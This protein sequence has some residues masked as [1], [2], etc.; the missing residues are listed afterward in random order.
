MIKYK[1]NCVGCR[2]IGLPCM[3]D[4]CS[5]KRVR[6]FY[7]DRCGGESRTLYVYDDE[8]ICGDCLLDMFDV[9]EED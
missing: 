9:V 8:Q 4:A 1:N 2:D 5:N 3:G 7:C 6:I